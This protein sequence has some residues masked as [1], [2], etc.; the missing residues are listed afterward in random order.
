M[1]N[2]TAPT[3]FSAGDSALGYLYQVRVGL[4][5]SLRRIATDC[6]RLAQK[7]RVRIVNRDVVARV[8]Q[9]DSDD[10]G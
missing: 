8:Q 4:P 3:S 2:T 10:A 5:W 9:A 6:L 7:K 1:S